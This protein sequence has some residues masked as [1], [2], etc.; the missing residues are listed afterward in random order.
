MTS[1][2]NQVATLFSS[3]KHKLPQIIFATVLFC[4]IIYLAYIIKGSSCT[5]SPNPFLSSF[6]YEDPYTNQIAVDVSPLL[7]KGSTIILFQSTIL[8]CIPLY[9]YML[10]TLFSFKHHTHEFTSSSFK[11]EHIS[12]SAMLSHLT[13]VKEKRP[14]KRQKAKKNIEV[15]LNESSESLATRCETPHINKEYT[16]IK[17][18]P[19]P[20]ITYIEPNTVIFNLTIEVYPFESN[21]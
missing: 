8:V 15:I 4:L 16:S 21:K 7:V 2:K 18:F 10:F 6:Y 20:V 9:T 1:E 14:I 12:K 3:S 19:L 17:K 5:S 13:C 11:Y